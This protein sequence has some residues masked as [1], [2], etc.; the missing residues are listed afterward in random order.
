MHSAPRNDSD[1]IAQSTPAPSE[2]AAPNTMRDP[3]RPGRV[4]RLVEWSRRRLATRGGYVLLYLLLFCAAW[5]P[6]LFTALACGKSLIWQT[7]GLSQQYVWYAYVGTW[8]RELFSNV[9]VSHT[10]ALPMWTMDSGYGTDV[11][12]AIGGMLLNPLYW[13]S[14]LIPGKYAEL[15]LEAVT[16][17]T[18][19]LAGL[20]F[21]AW[22]LRRGVTRSG[23]LVGA[24][25][26]AFSGFTAVMFTQPSF[27]VTL[28]A[29]PLVLLCADRVF[30]HK[31]PLPFVLVMAWCFAESYYDAYMM[32]VLL[33]L[34]CLASFFCV[35]ERT[36]PRKGRAVRLLGW[37]GAFVGCIVLALLLSG[38]LM[39]PQVMA[40][41]GSSRL[42]LARTHELLYSLGYYAQFLTQLVSTDNM[43]SDAFFG[44]S[45]VA[46]VALVL[47]VMRRRQHRGLFVLF[48]VLT[49]MLLLPI[50]GR[51]MNG[52]EYPSNRWA[53]GYALLVAYT[54]A[55][56]LPEALAMSARERHVAVGV[57]AAYG[58][59]V[60]FLPL[61]G[62]KPAFYAS[63]LVVLAALAVFV[64]ARTMR[65]THAI[66][67][68]GALAALSGAVMLTCYLAPNFTGFAGSLMGVGKS[69][70]FHASNGVEKFIDAAGD[71]GTAYDDTY[72]YDRTTPVAAATHNS[73]LVCGRMTPD[74]YNST[75]NQ[76]VGDFNASLGLVDTE[77]VNFRYGS[78]NS[79]S[80]LEALLGVRYFYLDDENSAMLPETFRSGRVIAQGPGRDDTYSL[81]E[82]DEVAPLAFTSTSY[83]TR[84][85]YDSLSLADRQKALLSALVLDE[86]DAANLT[87][88]SEEVASSANSQELAYTVGQAS[89][90]DV[91]EDG[92][93][94]TARCAGARVT[95]TFESPA[96][97]ET[98]L[99][100]TGLTY[101][102]IPY[103]A[104]YTDAEWSALGFIGRL[105]V[106]LAEPFRQETTN[107]PICVLSDHSAS[108]VY[109]MNDADHM[110][111]G[112]HDWLV[113]MGYSP[114]GRTSVTLEFKAPGTYSFKQM[115][116]VAQPM[117]GVDGLVD[118]LRSAGAQ[119]VRIGENELACTAQADR[120][121]QL[122]WSVAYSA[123]WKATV[124]GQE[125]PVH[126]ADLGFMS[127]EVPAGMHEVRL[128]YETPY[129]C[130]GCV[131]TLAGAVATAA[132]CLVRRGVLRRRMAASAADKV[133]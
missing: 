101:E 105:K 96:D 103:R 6:A 75:Y 11:I 26:Y 29:F 120:D 12:Q 90:C 79:R 64:G 17:A 57:V 23:A 27:I 121:C 28:A 118:D 111:G 69:Y 16:L 38:F 52:F 47:L 93:T 24:L 60:L 3:V 78:L 126:Q 106:R 94:I 55:R 8:I 92:K 15:G 89:G 18:L 31:S 53:W 50:C 84:A 21:S 7:D 110:Y 43:G 22:V 63:Y 125:V 82:T 71:S 10:F 99:E 1:E 19:F 115:R 25:A 117:E 123:G 68:A 77:G 4:D 32:C 70:Q 88:A 113:N 61:P 83:M 85:E 74:F 108:T 130:A 97:A 14:A 40:L 119:D 36:R 35:V 34:Y 33:V 48:V 76:G 104:R 124:D 58:V 87:D 54:C 67:S 73:G 5:V 39:L 122:F 91:S 56:L 44:L 127:V 102:D 81:W 72:R 80:M 20:T 107:G 45:A 98:Y 65:R 46:P 128:T 95:L 112:Q 129:L 13:T 9:F 114:E 49:A 30:A 133:A 59:A 42:E 62:S 109:Q 41:A 116:V 132:A 2:G 66:A 131:L 100:L 51:A 86:A 37:V